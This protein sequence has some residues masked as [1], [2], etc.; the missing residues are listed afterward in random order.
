[1]ENFLGKEDIVK[2]MNILNIDYKEESYSQYEKILFM[3]VS[4]IPIFYQISH[5]EF[6][7]GIPYI[8]YIPILIICL[9]PIIFK[10]SLL[11]FLS[12]Q[13][14]FLM[15]AVF[16]NYLLIPLI[17]FNVGSTNPILELSNI[18]LNFVFLFSII[19]IASRVNRVDIF[20][21]YMRYFLIGN[22]IVLT[23]GIILNFSDLFNVNNYSWLF[24]DTRDSRAYFSF[25][26]PNF[27]GIFLLIEI[28]LLL[29]LFIKIKSKY[30]LF[31]LLFYLFALLAT[32]S[33][34]SFYGLIIFCVMY[35]YFF[36]CYKTSKKLRLLIINMS[37]WLLIVYFGLIYDWK[38]LLSD[39]SGRDTLLIHNL[40]ELVKDGNLL[41]GI[42]PINYTSIAVFYPN[43]QMSDNWYVTNTMLY[44]VFGTISF[45]FVTLIS[46][47]YLFLIH[48]NSKNYKELNFVKSLTICILIISFFENLLYIP[49]VIV[50]FFFWLTAL[51][52]GNIGKRVNS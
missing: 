24:N 23:L 8:Q 52:V 27:A 41:T 39:S 14:K 50:S 3:L 31:L 13:A 21:N 22:S 29:Y 48:S 5:F 7:I 32:G 47:I 15:L 1:M 25:G 28:L 49:G 35:M 20:E 10:K 44:G 51:S 43:Y 40:N 2:R 26:H 12:L 45:V 36:I 38:E 17:S 11:I 6:G 37:I 33:R 19:I 30:L 46:I 34:T 16:L 4:A 9:L 42:G 18:I